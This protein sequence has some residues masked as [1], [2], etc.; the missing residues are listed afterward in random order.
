MPS[1]KVTDLTKPSAV[2]EE[3]RKDLAK[4]AVK[5][6]ANTMLTSEAKWAQVP[7]VFD[8]LPAHEKPFPIEPFPNERQ[9]I[10]FKMTDEDRMRRKIYLASQ[11]LT[12]REPV[13][14]PELERMVFNPIRRFY[15]YP[16]DKLFAS[17]A[18]YIG[19]ANVR[20]YRTMV[21]KLFIAYI[22][23]CVLWYNL[24]YNKTVTKFRFCFSMILSILKAIF[25][26]LRAG[27][28][29]KASNY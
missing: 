13:R 25:F 20:T 11:E 2:S 19:D 3:V 5:K 15:R 7:T 28:R 14:V 16:A 9:R 6:E 26:Y 17:L 22:G 10:P 24:K 21:P 23:G 29:R 27:K 12:D 8:D 4:Q 1:D 18:P